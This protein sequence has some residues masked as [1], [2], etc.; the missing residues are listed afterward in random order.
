MSRKR[1]KE[2]LELL[3]IQYP[4]HFPFECRNKQHE[5]TGIVEVTYVRRKKEKIVVDVTLRGPEH[6]E[7]D[8]YA[9]YCFRCEH[10]RI[11]GETTISTR[12]GNIKCIVDGNVEECGKRYIRLTILPSGEYSPFFTPLHLELEVRKIKTSKELEQLKRYKKTREI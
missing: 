3:G 4:L 7:R 11:G 5:T 12:Y 9:G 6:L 1:E 8:F 10:A 2:L